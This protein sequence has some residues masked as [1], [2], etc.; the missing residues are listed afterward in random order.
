MCMDIV[1]V[2]AAVINTMTESNLERLYFTYIST[3]YF[4]I[5]GSQEITQTE[6]QWK[7]SAQ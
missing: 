6:Q 5:K 3:L 1:L 7:I 2:S 4:I